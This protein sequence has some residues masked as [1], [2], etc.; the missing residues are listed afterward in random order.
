MGT[1][2]AFISGHGTL[3]FNQFF[4]VYIPE[5]DKALE[6]NH[7]FIIGDYNGTDTLAQEYLKDKTNNVTICHCFDK[8]R[9]RVNKYRLNS[10]HWIYIANFESDDERDSYMTNHSDYDIA[11]SLYR[12]S[13]TQKN[14]NRR[15]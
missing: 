12:N 9:Y 3:T 7:N 11:I 1:K 15:K 8:P 10:E 2:T 13:G 6:L 4:D 14:L 5:I